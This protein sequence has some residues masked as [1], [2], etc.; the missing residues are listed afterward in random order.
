MKSY[1]IVTKGDQA[2]LEAREVPVPQPKPHEV[3]I[4]VHAAGLNRGELI[5][6]LLGAAAAS[7]FP[8]MLY[9]TF[10]AAHSITA[11]EGAVGG[12]G[13]GLALIW[14]PVAM[15]LSVAYSIAVLRE[16]KG[17]VRVSTQTSH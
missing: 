17:K 9:S 13:L 5:V 10:D 6:G 11:Y 15:I 7:V 2:T 14:W 8:I 12:R 16:F 3:V 4:R 1:W